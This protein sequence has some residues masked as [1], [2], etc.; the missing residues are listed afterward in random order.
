[1]T[2]TATLTL[3]AALETW[4]QTQSKEEGYSDLSEYVCELLKRER[5]RKERD[6]IDKQLIKSLNSGPAKVM[7]DEAWKEL[8]V[9]SRQRFE[10]KSKKNAP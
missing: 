2:T 9:K 7:T 5:I 6:E 8:R 10:A 4:V 3:P 1:M